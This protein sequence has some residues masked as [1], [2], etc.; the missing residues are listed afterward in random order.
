MTRI[1][2]LTMLFLA[3]FLLNCRDEDPVWILNVRAVTFAVDGGTGPVSGCPFVT[4]RFDNSSTQRTERCRDGNRVKVWR[5]I[6]HDETILYFVGCAGYESS[7]EYT[8]IFKMEN[9]E[10]GSGHD[11]PEVIISNTVFLYAE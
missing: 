10:E 6:E 5:N 9:A 4:W 11:G 2:A 3:C 8:A 1:L 7:P